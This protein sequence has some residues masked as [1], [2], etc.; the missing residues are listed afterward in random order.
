MTSEGQHFKNSNCF[1]HEN[2]NAEKTWK[3]EFGYKKPNEL[4]GWKYCIKE[5]AY[6]H[7]FCCS[8]I[9]C[10]SAELSQ[11]LLLEVYCMC[12]HV[13]S[14]KDRLLSLQF[15]SC[16]QIVVFQWDCVSLVA[17]SYKWIETAQLF[18]QID[19]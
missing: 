10:G 2:E 17:N 4:G 11:E 9:R 5:H 1:K 6:M 12:G 3:A 13:S 8:K 19:P 18:G 15:F 14:Q 7:D 16:G